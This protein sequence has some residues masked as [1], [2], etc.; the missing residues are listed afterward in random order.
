MLKDSRSVDCGDKQVF[1]EA[2]LVVLLPHDDDRCEFVR[3][4]AGVEL[5]IAFWLSTQNNFNFKI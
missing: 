3:L 2:S 5:V 4:K 1:E